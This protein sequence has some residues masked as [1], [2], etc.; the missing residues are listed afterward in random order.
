MTLSSS[1]ARVPSWAPELFALIDWANNPD[2]QM[3]WRGEAAAILG[4]PAP[5]FVQVGKFR[6]CATGRVNTHLGSPSSVQIS[7]NRHR[8]VFAACDARLDDRA[9]LLRDLELDEGALYNDADLLACAYLKWSEDLFDHLVGEFAFVLVDPGCDLVLLG[10]DP[11][12]IRPLYYGE[13]AD[14]IAVSSTAMPLSRLAWIGRDLDSQRLLSH[15]T[16][17]ED[18]ERER[19]FFKSIRKLPGEHALIVGPGKRK[20][21]SHW[22]FPDHR[23]FAKASLTDCAQEI[24]ATFE[25]AVIDQMR[26]HDRVASMLSGGLDSSAIVVVAR[27][28]LLAAGKAPLLTFS[29]VFPAIAGRFPDADESSWINPVVAT[30]NIESNMIPLEGA[31][32]LDA[33]M[34]DFDQPGTHPNAYLMT[35]LFAAARAKGVGV[36]FS[37]HDGDSAIGY[38][39]DLFK[40]LFFGLRWVELYHQLRAF[41]DRKPDRRTLRGAFK[42]LVLRESQP[43]WLRRLRTDASAESL[44]RALP[45]AVNPD[46]ARAHGYAQRALDSRFPAPHML[47]SNAYLENGSEL[48]CRMARCHELRCALPFFDQRLLKLSMSMPNRVK[49]DRNVNRLV[50]RE[51]M[52]G[53]LPESVRMRMGKQDISPNVRLAMHARELDEAD[54][55]LGDSGYLLE[56]Y[57]IPDKVHDLLRSFREDPFS[58]PSAEF[59]VL[60]YSII[61]VRW[62]THHAI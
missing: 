62:R 18:E 57:C 17:I 2:V 50:M 35:D 9:R 43:N 36:I 44:F 26:D 21:W 34:L 53:R 20:Y 60:F 29:G 39:L 30:G 59:F 28:A 25:A 22:R 19:S 5:E 8:G 38:G 47:V 15:F 49:W 45:D 14:R 12:G 42:S 41:V 48:L 3:E 51:A 11:L 27:D 58:L 40:E 33:A 46:F 54:Q 23:R 4:T 13:T 16:L 52:R 31:R 24:G 32:P 7:V 61:F 1:L 10:R 55:L 37:G 56:P 6:V